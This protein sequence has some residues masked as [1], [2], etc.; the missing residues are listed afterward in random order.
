MAPVRICQ[1]LRDLAPTGPQRCACELAR[2]LDRSRFDVRVVAIRGG[3][4]GDRLQ[5]DGIPV[6]VLGTRRTWALFKMP[7]LTEF[8]RSERINL[9]HSHLFRAD[10]VGRPAARL[11]AV[12]HVVHTAHTGEGRFR[13]W[14]FAYA[15]FLGGYCD[16][17]ICLSESAL[18][19]HKTHT[20]LPSHAY[21]VIPNGVDAAAFAGDDERRRELR[22]QWKIN[23]DQMVAAYVGRLAADKGIDI[24]LAAISHLGARGNPVDV[25]IA[26]DGK[27]RH[28]V[29]N[30]IAH[31]EGGD[32][33][34]LLG[35]VDDVPA[36]LSAVDMLV[37]PSRWEGWPLAVGE[38]MAASLPVI[39]TDVPGVRDLVVDGQTGVLI[40]CGKVV[41]L[42]DAIMRLAGDAQLRAQLGRAGRKRIR[43]EFP[44]EATVAAHEKL[45][46]EVVGA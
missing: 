27:K 17:I 41:A 15:R 42:S 36:L 32:H 28:L 9:V 20:G 14:Q 43:E 10:L 34:R 18:E 6:T 16:R 25:V 7:M 33:C 26:G 1:L 45:Y 40:E 8:L 35:F 31:G 13:P 4:L 39:G 23:P 22:S 5:R 30:F 29:E 3:A 38:A 21:T 46:E 2:R 37:M 19:Y 11:A 24:L 12:P 44:I